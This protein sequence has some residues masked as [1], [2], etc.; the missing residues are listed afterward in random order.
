MASSSSFMALFG[1]GSRHDCMLSMMH[2]I[3]RGADFVFHTASPYTFDVED[4]ERDLVEPALKGTKN[5]LASVAKS[6]DSVRR[7]V[8]T[9]SVVGGV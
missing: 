1:S 8:L 4:F 5:V 7:V 9:S 6:K 2:R 3:R